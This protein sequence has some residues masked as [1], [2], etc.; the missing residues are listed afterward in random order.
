MTAFNMGQTAGELDFEEVRGRY[1]N[2]FDDWI[3]AKGYWYAVQ[4]IMSE[5][6]RLGTVADQLCRD[7]VNIVILG[8]SH[9]TKMDKDSWFVKDRIYANC[10]FWCGFGDIEKIED[11]AHFVQTDGE[12]V[13]LLRFNDGALEKRVSRKL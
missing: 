12:T 9:D 2:L 7:G 10:G 13:E 11:N 1:R 5:M 8:H 4:M 3:R 6:N